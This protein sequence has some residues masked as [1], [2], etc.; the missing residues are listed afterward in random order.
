[1][2]RINYPASE[3]I[4]FNIEEILPTHEEVLNSQGIYPP[5][6]VSD[7]IQDMYKASRLLFNELANPVGIVTQVEMNEFAEIYA[8]EGENDNDNLLRHLYPRAEQLALFALTI[9]EEVSTKIELLFQKNEFPVGY[10]LD[11]VASIAADKAAEILQ[12]KELEKLK[13]E[14]P[15][16]K[17]TRVLSYSPGYCG[18]HISGQRKL[19]AQLKPVKIGISLND[20]YLMTP[21]KSVSGVLIAG[22]INIHL[23]TPNYSF[24][25][26]CKTHACLPRMKALRQV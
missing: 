6:N 18:W 17:N 12:E 11:T 24:C 4:H 20:S 10:M 9:G 1:M 2:A 8:G 15:A 14:N 25:K 3:I 22:D 19:F 23:F 21:L 26:S 7:K 5:S 13:R 16:V